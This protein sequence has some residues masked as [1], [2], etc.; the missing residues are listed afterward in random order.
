MLTFVKG[1]VM[2]GECSNIRRYC[3][4]KLKGEIPIES[5]PIG[6]FLQRW[7]AGFINAMQLNATF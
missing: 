3:I 4:K 1:L 6:S 7:I 2:G 5:D